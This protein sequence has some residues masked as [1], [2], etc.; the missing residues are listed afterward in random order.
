MFT[1]YSVPLLILVK[2]FFLGVCMNYIRVGL[3]LV[4]VSSLMFGYH[5]K[6]KYDDL[7]VELK[8]K[9]LQAVIA[10]EQRNNEYNQTTIT[11]NE[12][13][14]ADID[15][16]VKNFNAIVNRVDIRNHSDSLHSGKDT[17][18]MHSTTRAAKDT[19]GSY[20]KEFAKCRADYKRIRTE[21]LILAKDSD[22]N[23]TKYNSL[24]NYYKELYNISTKGE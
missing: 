5:Y 24:I 18:Q 6:S 2:A 14:H 20:Y 13:L 22:I 10:K 19:S 15:N 9:E 11:F 3:L 23:N 8:E 12:K 16:V 7:M 1:F 4:F 17:E 21:Y